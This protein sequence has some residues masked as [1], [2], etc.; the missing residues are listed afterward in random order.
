M[1]N[2]TLALLLS[3]TAVPAF[4]GG[5]VLEFP[6]LTYPD[7]SQTTTSTKGCDTATQPAVAVCK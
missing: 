7:D 5:V 6:R 3:F 1:R 4:A 2:L